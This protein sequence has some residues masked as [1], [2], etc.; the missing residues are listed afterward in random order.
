MTD[1]L[2]PPDT[3]AEEALPPEGMWPKIYRALAPLAGGI[4]LDTLDLATFGPIG[5]Y[6]GWLIGA[7]VG[8][9]MAG[10]YE[11]SGKGRLLFA[12]LSALYMTIPFTEILPVATTISAV[13][14][15]RGSGKAG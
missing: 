7:A 9:W 8:Y 10:I 5:F 6:V 4:L 2:H 15:F 12:F 14:R 13:A 1:H 11:F 3:T